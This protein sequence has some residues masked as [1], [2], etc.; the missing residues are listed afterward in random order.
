MSYKQ[1]QYQH[2]FREETK[3]VDY[4]A[5]LVIHKGDFIV[6]RF[7]KLESK[8]KQIINSDKLQCPYLKL[9]ATKG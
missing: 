4:F 6:T 3:L 2:I 1:V 9:S 8:G 7:Q 5:N